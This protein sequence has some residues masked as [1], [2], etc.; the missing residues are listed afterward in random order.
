[1][2]NPIFVK[3]AGPVLSI[4]I[5]ATATPGQTP[6]HS[7]EEIVRRAAQQKL[8][9]TEA[10]ANLL[11]EETKTFEVYGRDGSVKKRRVVRSTFIIYQLSKDPAKITEYR[12]VSAVDG[13][14]LGE[15]D[16]RAQNFFEQLVKVES[17]AKELERIETESQRYD[18]E[19][20]VSNLTLFQS[21]ALA[22]PLRSSF[23]FKLSGKELID[24]R[25]VHVIE[26]DQI[27]ASPGVVIDRVVAGH[28]GVVYDV[29]LKGLKDVNERLSGKLWIDSQTFQVVRENRLLSIQ[30]TGFPTR[31]PVSENSFEFQKSAFGILTPKRITHLQFDIDKKTRSSVKD[32]QIVFEY[33][34]FTRPDVDVRSDDVKP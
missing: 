30:P 32:V 21:V 6:S 27:N 9:Y 19:L 13:K 5:A 4:C 11:S 20:F 26:Y 29:D 25:E 14:P 12:N 33:D 16:A 15:T 31:I 10:F 3:V 23:R 7:V 2:L 28:P 1:M 18:E 17:S 24:G 22:E 8:V 34:K